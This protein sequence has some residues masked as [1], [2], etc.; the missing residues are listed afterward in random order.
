MASGRRII[1]VGRYFSESCAKNRREK[2]GFDIRPDTEPI[3]QI[4]EQ[5]DMKKIRL[6][7]FQ[8]DF[9][10]DLTRT[11][12][13]FD[14]FCRGIFTGSIVYGYP[15]FEISVRDLDQ[16]PRKGK[17]SRARLEST[18]L[19]DEE[20]RRLGNDAVRTR[21]VLDGQQRLTSLYR[22]LKD[23]DPVWVIFKTEAEIEKDFPDRNVADLPLE[24]VFYSVEGRED[25][26]RPS[27]R[28]GTLYK[29]MREANW[30]EKEVREKCFDNTAF[31][32]AIESED[33]RTEAFKNVIVYMGKLED[34]LKNQK[35]I[36]NFNFEMTGEKF[37]LFFERSNS[38]GIQLTFIDILEAKLIHGFDLRKRMEEFEGTNKEL[39]TVNREVIARA[40]AYVV[41]DGSKAGKNYILGKLK[42]EDFEKNWDEITDL[43]K[44]CVYF[45]KN[46]HYI[47]S[48]DWI[49]YRNA[50]IPMMM[51]LK[52]LPHQLRGDE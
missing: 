16:R 23:I 36:A 47:L 40:V 22:A 46:N 41:S 6:P 17:G 26:D 9:V 49:P 20:I 11:Y 10:W 24:N 45:L 12:E 27:I 42:A 8:R 19:N 33:L 31:A 29:K 21:L 5:I 3:V 14:S 15:T 43:Y 38:L 25:P 32:A 2:V 48:S 34:V 13:L 52:E 35:L 1:V 44:K 18:Y 28:L 30:L 7:E 39:G 4:I 51:F 50:L 37:A